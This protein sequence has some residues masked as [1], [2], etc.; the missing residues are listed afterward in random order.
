MRQCD[1]ARTNPN[2]DIQLEVFPELSWTAGQLRCGYDPTGS[3]RLVAE[4][5]RALRRTLESSAA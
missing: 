4:A 3:A 2:W 5:D 1:D